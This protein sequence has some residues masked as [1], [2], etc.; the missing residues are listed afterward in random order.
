MDQPGHNVEEAKYSFKEV[1]CKVKTKA[2]ATLMGQ[3]G[4]ASLKPTVDAL[5]VEVRRLSSDRDLFRDTCD[6]LRRDNQ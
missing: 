3:V 1:E 2:P 5:Q 4:V 6:R